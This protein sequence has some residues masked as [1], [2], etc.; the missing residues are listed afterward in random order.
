M[1]ASAIA[2]RQRRYSIPSRS[3]VNRAG[4][5]PLIDFGSAANAILS[6]AGR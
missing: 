6:C 3:S 4:A 5:M 2:V 1:E